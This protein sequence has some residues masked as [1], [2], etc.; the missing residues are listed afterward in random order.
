MSNLATLDER[1][2]AGTGNGVICLPLTLAP[3]FKFDFSTLSAL[4]LDNYLYNSE[5]ELH[6]CELHKRMS[7]EQMPGLEL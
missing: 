1:V 3:V 5:C 2:E 7:H 4:K 6:H